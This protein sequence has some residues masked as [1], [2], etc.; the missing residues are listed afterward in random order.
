M[1]PTGTA[2]ENF[3][4][5]TYYRT[6]LSPSGSAIFND[7]NLPDQLFWKDSGK[8]LPVDESVK[9]S[10]SIETT[11][12]GWFERAFPHA[13]GGRS[14]RPG[15]VLLFIFRLAAPCST[16]ILPSSRRS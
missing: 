9:K 11:D 2:A 12:F 3:V 10:L 6:S 14:F 5:S 15:T 16:G 1:A 13:L 7:R 8:P 4:T